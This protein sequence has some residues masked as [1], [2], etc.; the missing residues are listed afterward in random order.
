MSNKRLRF[1]SNSILD[2]LQFVSQ[3]LNLHLHSLHFSLKSCR[4]N[5]HFC[6]S[7]LNLFDG[8]AQSINIVHDIFMTGLENRKY[9]LLNHI[10]TNP[11]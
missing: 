1:N 2:G 7:A 11:S 10:R 9:I 8:T 3:F 4:D 5:S 6:C